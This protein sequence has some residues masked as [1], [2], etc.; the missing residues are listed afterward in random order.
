MSKTF[1]SI[2]G[3]L[4][5]GY[6][7]F[8]FFFRLESILI[9][10]AATEQK[11]FVACGTGFTC[12]AILVVSVDRIAANSLE[13]IELGRLVVNETMLGGNAHDVRHLCVGL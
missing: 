5:S 2:E 11:I 9:G 13:R 6:V 3:T 7:A 1:R 12:V 4:R 10:A 8:Q